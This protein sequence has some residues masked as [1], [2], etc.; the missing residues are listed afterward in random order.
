[1]F[2]PLFSDEIQSS[3]AFANEVLVGVREVVPTKA[4]YKSIT[5]NARNTKSSGN[6]PGTLYSKVEAHGCI[7]KADLRSALILETS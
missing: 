6:A 1:M 4:P 5:D 7:I 3:S 2:A